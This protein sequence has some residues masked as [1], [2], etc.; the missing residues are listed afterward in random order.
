[1]DAA[2]LTAAALGAGYLLD[3]LFGDPAWLPHPVVGFGRAISVGER[4]LNRGGA[5]R[6]FLCGSRGE[7]IRR[8][9]LRWW[10]S[11][12]SSAWRTAR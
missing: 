10:R 5:V 12:S 7:R 8:R 11:A 9:A 2:Q 3:L 4:V 1:M 6:R